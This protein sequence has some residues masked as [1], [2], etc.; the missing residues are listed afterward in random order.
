MVPWVAMWTSEMSNMKSVRINQ[1]G[2]I[3]GKRDSHGIYWV[4]YGNSPEQGNPLFGHVHP[5][6]QVESMRKPKYQV[7]GKKL[8]HPFYWILNRLD[9]Q[10]LGEETITTQTPPVCKPCVGM[11]VKECPHLISMGEDVPV[12]EVAQ[13][14]CI[15]AFGDLI[16]PGKTPRKNSLVLYGSENTPYFC[17][18]QLV[19]QLQVWKR[20]TLDQ[21]QKKGH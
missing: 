11:S 6:R 7:C 18:R 1:E 2:V 13:Y 3:L 15:G 20:I 10:F 14:S 5:K 21:F 9:S 16:L 8:D 4:E 19:V 12:L 17:G